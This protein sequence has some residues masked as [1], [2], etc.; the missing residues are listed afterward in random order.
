MGRIFLCYKGFVPTLFKG[1]NV[2]FTSRLILYKRGIVIGQN[3]R[4]NKYVSVSLEYEFTIFTM[5]YVCACV[6]VCV[7]VYVRMC[8]CYDFFVRHNLKNSKPFIT[9]FCI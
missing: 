9:K 2:I 7:C 1:Y 5:M 4:V 3:F 8:V 6:R